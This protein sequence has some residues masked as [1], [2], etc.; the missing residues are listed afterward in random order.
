MTSDDK[1]SA[2]T[3]ESRF[4]LLVASR[5]GR[6][7]SPPF[8]CPRL[9]SAGGG[10]EAEGGT[11]AASTQ[12]H[13]IRGYCE[14][15]SLPEFGGWLGAEMTGG[16]FPCHTADTETRTFTMT[17]QERGEQ[18]RQ[19]KT[20]QFDRGQFDGSQAIRASGFDR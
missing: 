8:S 5:P 1:N 4:L 13:H 3:R 10:S 9:L 16:C 17:D 11:A 14:R 19:P 2:G 6:G 12:G 18:D 15:L 20:C 7:D